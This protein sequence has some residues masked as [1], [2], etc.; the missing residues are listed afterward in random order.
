MV[1][2]EQAVVGGALLQR[3]EAHIVVVVAE[4]ALLRLRRLV[5]RVEFGSV[6][7]DRVAPAQQHVRIVA[8]GDVMGLVDAGLHLGE[9][10]ARTNR[11]RLR[12][13]CGQ[14][15]HGAHGRSDRRG[16]ERAPQEVAARKA[17]GDDFAHRP[18]AGP[19]AARSVGLLELT[20]GERGLAVANVLVHGWSLHW[21]DV[22]PF[23]FELASQYY[24]TMTVRRREALL[25]KDGAR[26]FGAKRR[27]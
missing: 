3:D 10:E 11:L 8:L 20:G 9:G 13:V 15:R 18:V 21:I 17:G 27:P 12:L 14:Q 25:G 2:D 26:R 24:S 19:V 6:R 22:E 1:D 7:K 5:H 16:C 4:L 23:Q